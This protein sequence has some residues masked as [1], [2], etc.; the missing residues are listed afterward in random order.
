MARMQLITIGGAVATNYHDKH[1][2]RYFAT[3]QIWSEASTCLKRQVGATLVKDGHVIATG[4]NGAPPGAIHCNELGP[5]GLV[6]GCYLV[7]MK[8]KRSIHAEHNAILQAARH[9]HSTNGAVM[10][11]TLEPCHECQMFMR[12][13]GI[14]EWYWIECKPDRHTPSEPV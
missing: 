9:G 3:A 6:V 11:V 8:C 10:Y 2:A 1:K 7:D 13:A 4:Y 14:F 12:G 5:D